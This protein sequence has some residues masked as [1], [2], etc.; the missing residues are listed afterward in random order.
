VRDARER[1]RDILEA[2]E[3]IERYSARG[4]EDFITDELVQTWIVRHL[5]IIGEAAR[6]V[7]ADVRNLVPEIPWPK[8]TGM[9]HVLVHDYFGIDLDL[10]WAVVEH[11]LAPLRTGITQLLERLNCGK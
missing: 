6:G 5:Q 3:K 9:R 10:V 4:R 11:E 2:I 1:L 7:P 8:I